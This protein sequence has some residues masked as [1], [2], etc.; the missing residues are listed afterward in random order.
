MIDIISKCQAD[1][2]YMLPGGVHISLDPV[3]I[4]GLQFVL[5]TRLLFFREAGGSCLIDF[6]PHAVVPDNVYII[7]PLH[8]HH[9]QSCGSVICID[10]DA[11]SLPLYHRQLLYLLKYNST[12]SLP[13]QPGN[14]VSCFDILSSLLP[15][16]TAAQLKRLLSTWI[17]ESLPPE[18][19]E[20]FQR[21]DHY[22]EAADQFIYLLRNRE[23]AYDTC[24]ITQLATDMYC[25]ERNLQRICNY[26]FGI[27]TKDIIKYHLAIKAIYLLAT[28]NR[29]VSAIACELGFSDTTVFDR[30]IR[31]ATGHSPSQLRAA[32]ERSCL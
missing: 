29:S 18:L 5:H 19:L 32:L 14:A 26:I 31:R 21:H 2:A 10:I 8:F 9:L 7:Q 17:E 1:K 28:M 27:G 23:L 15:D 25:S 30:Y 22:L 6:V 16:G 20:K 3:H 12:K 13:I 4:Q 24:R 11:F